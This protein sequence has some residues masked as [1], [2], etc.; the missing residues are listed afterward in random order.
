VF[1]EQVVNLGSDVELQQ[2]YTANPDYNTR[3]VRDGIYT[4]HWRFHEADGDIEIAIQGRTLSWIGIGWRPST[5]TP[6]CRANFPR[7]SDRPMVDDRYKAFVNG[8]AIEPGATVTYLM[9]N[10]FF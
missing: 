9:L 7:M 8:Q 1:L 10:N 2:N 5:F 6:A 3:I 4:I